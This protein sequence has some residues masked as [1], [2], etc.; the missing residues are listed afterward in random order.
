MFSTVPVPTLIWPFESIVN[1]SASSPPSV[2]VS[3]SPSGLLALRGVP[4]DVP[5]GEFSRTSRSIEAA[6]TAFPSLST[7]TG[8]AF[9][10]RPANTFTSDTTNSCFPEPAGSV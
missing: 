6:V 4:T 3:T 1:L 10:A 9:E 8:A 2:N 5:A 7:I